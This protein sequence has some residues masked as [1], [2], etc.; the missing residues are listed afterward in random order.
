MLPTHIYVFTAVESDIRFVKTFIVLRDIEWKLNTDIKWAAYL[1]NSHLWVHTPSKYL[2]P[3]FCSCVLYHSRNLYKHNS[4][5]PLTEA[6][7]LLLQILNTFIFMSQ[8]IGNIVPKLCVAALHLCDS[9]RGC[10]WWGWQ[11]VMGWLRWMLVSAVGRPG[12]LTV[13]I[14]GSGAALWCAHIA[15]QHNGLWR[16]NNWSECFGPSISLRVGYLFAI[17]LRFL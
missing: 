17:W 2:T 7:T 16:A 6:M 14:W 15:G 5:S 9:V 13:H 10:A 11:V 12:H 8:D 3:C 4:H 1:C